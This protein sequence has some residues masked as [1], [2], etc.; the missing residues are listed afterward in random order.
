MPKIDES[1]RPMP[2]IDL[3]KV[4]FIVEKSREYAGE[5][6]GAEADDSNPTDDDE[7]VMLTE[8]AGPSI[9]RELIDSSRT[10]TSTKLRRRSRLPG[11]DGATS[12]RRSGKSQSHRRTSG[13]R[14]RPGNTFS[15]WSFCR[16]TSRT[17]C[18]PLAVPAR[19]WGRRTKGDA[20]SAASAEFKLFQKGKLMLYMFFAASCAGL[21]RGARADGKRGTKTDCD[22]EGRKAERF[23]CNCQGWGFGTAVPDGLLGSR[24]R[25]SAASRRIFRRSAT[26]STHGKPLDELGSGSSRPLRGALRKEVMGSCAVTVFGA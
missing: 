2:E 18:P 26:V 25:G 23:F 15:K 10:S 14:G 5:E 17:R 19:A 13:P 1:D 9:R 11:S 21:R 7:Q 8:A 4:C 16:T 12:S 20:R 3:A 24:R 6:I 22:L